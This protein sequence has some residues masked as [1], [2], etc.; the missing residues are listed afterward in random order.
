MTQGV[1][2]LGKGFQ[3]GDALT[4]KRV[5]K[6][7]EWGALCPR[8]FKSA[9]ERQARVRKH[10]EVFTPS[11]VCKQM[12]DVADEGWFRPEND[13]TPQDLLFRGDLPA[14]LLRLN[15][16]KRWQ[17]YVSQRRLEVACGEAPYLTARYDAATGDIIPWELRYGVLDRKLRVFPKT[18]T[19]L[20]WWR[21]A[22][23]AFEATYGYEYQGDNLF[24]ARCNLLLTYEE[25]HRRRW[26]EEPPAERLLAL[27]EVIAWN[28]WQMDGLTHLPPGL[29]ALTM[30]DDL[31]ADVPTAA[32]ARPC[33]VRIEGRE[34]LYATLK[35]EKAMKFDFIIGNPPYQEEVENNGR[36]TPIYGAFMDAVYALGE[37]VCLITPA[38]F[39]FNAGQ[40]P[41]AWNKKM[42]AD[43]HLKVV[44]YEADGTRFFPGTDI[45]G[46][47]AITYRDANHTFGAIEAFTPWA[48][49]RAVLGKVKP[50]M[51]YALSEIVTGAVPYRFSNAVRMER[52]ECVALIEKS[53][54]LRTN[55]LDNLDGK[56]FFDAPQD[57]EAW[58]RIFGLLKGK[59]VY[60]WIK[61]KYLTVPPIFEHWKIHVPEANGSG[62]L[63][64]ALSAPIIGEPLLGATQ[65]FI[66]I[67]C[68]ET[69]EEAE[70]CLKYIK[71]KFAR[72]LLG[73]LKVTQHN[74]KAT[75]AYI[76]LQDFT[77]ES[78]I[79]W[80]VSVAEVDRQLYRKYG[81]SAEEVAFIESKVR[82]MA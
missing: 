2:S 62:T 24:L 26:H 75:W 81:L 22:L 1:A 49:M 41:K 34:T 70:A 47:V 25:A 14:T 69:R 60:R 4:P 65:T 50:L 12:I 77:S 73:I 32:T 9:E 38:R 42:L 82:E 80:T 55:V 45:K 33:R 78:D 31:F 16:P 18:L 8:A 6:A 44:R 63:G 27:A 13:I 51:K 74:P 15:E 71:G 43:A 76:P 48:E 52:P 59:R 66:S 61:R 56:L 5:L 57:K 53:F 21:W 28:L 64:E 68:F 23:R 46:G 72:A 54:D 58:V 35:G 11:W 30:E 79:D 37:R 7:V 29:A 67:G 40:T 17:A 3:A 36:S 19:R 20:H 10:G 39:L